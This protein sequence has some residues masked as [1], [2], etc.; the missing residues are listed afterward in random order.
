MSKVAGLIDDAMR[1]IEAELVEQELAG[2]VVGLDRTAGAGGI[3]E[4][5]DGDD[6]E[7]GFA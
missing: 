7:E 5:W 3:L 6:R 2:A 4:V 1:L